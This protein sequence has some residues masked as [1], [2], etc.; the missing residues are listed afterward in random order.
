MDGFNLMWDI[1]I[2]EA[3]GFLYTDVP[4]DYVKKYSVRDYAV[5]YDQ[6]EQIKKWMSGRSRS[7]GWLFF[8]SGP[9]FSPGTYPNE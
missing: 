3:E 2:L 4:E 6:Q 1:I 9:A 5:D 7:V 8:N